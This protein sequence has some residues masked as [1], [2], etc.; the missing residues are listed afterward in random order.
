MKAVKIPLGLLA[1]VVVIIGG[2][3]IYLATLD[4]NSYKAEIREEVKKATGRNLEIAGDIG[5]ELSMTPRLTVSGVRFQ[6]AEWGTRPDMA[7][8]G[9][10]DVV[11]NLMPLLSSKIDVQRVV[12]RDV[13]LLL[14]TDKSGRGNWDVAGGGAGKP[15]AGERHDGG[16]VP[17]IGAVT[18]ENIKITYRD[19]A[20]GSQNSVAIETIGLKRTSSGA[21]DTRIKLEV[22]GQVIDVTGVLPAVS[23]I[24]KPGEA[25]PLSLGGSAFG[26]AIDVAAT[27]TVNQG[28]AGALKIDI[29]DLK[30]SVEGS[31]V[32]GS[33]SLA[34]GGARPMVTADI[35]STLL[36]LV[37][38]R[39][40]APKSEGG[41]GGG[42]SDKNPLDEPLPLEG[43]KAADADIKAAVKTLKLTDKL[44]V[45]DVNLVATLNAGLLTIQPSSAVLSGGKVDLSGTLDGRQ[46]VAKISVAEKWTGADFGA[47]AKI[48]QP[49]DLLAAKGDAEAKLAGAGETPRQILATLGGH[50]ALIIRE[51]KVDNAYWELIAADVA[52]QFLPFLDGSD[53]GKL[54]CMVSRFDIQHGIATSKAMV[55]DSDRVIVAG[56]GTI[57]L[58]S[59][60]LDLKLTPKPKNASLVSLAVPLLISGPATSPTVIPDPLAVAKGVDAI[61]LAGVNPLTLALPFLSA[62]SAD[63]PCPAAIAIAEGKPVP[64]AVPAATGDASKT[65]QEEKPGA[66]KGLFDSLKKVVD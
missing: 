43:L 27:V 38:L 56:E 65:E 32:A 4:F 28:K 63:E 10:L 36:D 48:F 19:G 46:P 31:D 33:A 50:T 16:G 30:A 42:G 1:V 23:A 29:A 60:E 18:L 17:D 62:G 52:T 21:L 14:K 8:V 58:A 57:K 26:F 5:L 7:T 9:A 64:K 66:I 13:D 3:A 41:A 12:L 39:A 55:V 22:D 49:N 24:I 25:L 34:L 61:A 11:V 2:G 40:K 6:N 35:R 47:L 44:S 15:S 59:Q 53:R 51:G 54:N 20:K 37:A 45:S